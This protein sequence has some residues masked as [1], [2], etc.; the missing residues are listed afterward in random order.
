MGAE[1]RVIEINGNQLVGRESRGETEENQG[2][3]E[4]K[5]KHGEEKRFGLSSRVLCQA[6]AMGA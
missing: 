4:R 3:E 6:F 1:I 5:T 2:E